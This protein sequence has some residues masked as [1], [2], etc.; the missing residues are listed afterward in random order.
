MQN[1]FNACNAHFYN[2]PS[3]RLHKPLCINASKKWRK[4]DRTISENFGAFLFAVTRPVPL[5]MI[6]KTLLNKLKL[7]LGSDL[8]LSTASPKI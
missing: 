1:Y 8:T 3:N 5:R 4:K 6:P 2:I 7:T